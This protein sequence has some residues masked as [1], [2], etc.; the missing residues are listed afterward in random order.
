M[1]KLFS[2][3]MVTLITLSSFGHNILK[4]STCWQAG[5][6]QFKGEIFD[7]NQKVQVSVPNGF[8]LSL[9]VSGDVIQ[10][11]S[12]KPSLSSNHR[13][14][15][16][17]TTN[18]SNRAFVVTAIKN[19]PLT[20]TYSVILTCTYG[21]SN[22][23]SN[24]AQY[25]PVNSGTSVCSGGGGLPVTLVNFAVKRNSD[26]TADVSWTTTFEANNKYFELQ[27]SNDGTSW[28]T[29]A[30]IFAASEDG[31]SS[32]PTNYKYKI[33]ATTQSK[34]ILAGFGSLAAIL[35]FGIL[36]G[37]MKRKNGV[38]ALSLML[39]VFAGSLLSCQK[40]TNA[41]PDKV[42]A[43]WSFL[44]LK[45]ADKDGTIVIATSVIKVN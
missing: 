36:I 38:V 45:Q 33:A 37:T 20:G 32:T 18:G 22:G 35:L 8:T 19:N 44:R 3:L 1:K 12:D 13:V 39:V 30:L 41:P 11:G 15:T 40:D 4:K 6:F 23:T 43:K 14:L 17:K 42:V 2:I 27:G 34:L 26:Y 28:T 25:S 24:D 31:N 21:G 5:N 9:I 7:A 10:T 16:F 29:E